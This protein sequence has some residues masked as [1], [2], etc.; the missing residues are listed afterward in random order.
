MLLL[1]V[2]E[3]ASEQF[4][5]FIGDFTQ[6]LFQRF[7]VFA[8]EVVI[9]AAQ[10]WGG[11]SLVAQFTARHFIITWLG[12]VVGVGL[13]LGWILHHGFGWLA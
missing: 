4:S 5:R 8:I 9:G 1:F 13:R 6:P 11:G 10:R 2:P 3:L 12:R 7:A